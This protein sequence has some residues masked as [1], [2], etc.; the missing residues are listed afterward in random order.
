MTG[1]GPKI[2]L[3]RDTWSSRL[4]VGSGTNDSTRKKNSVT[5]TTM[6]A[7]TTLDH[8]LAVAWASLLAM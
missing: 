3:S 5:E 6:N 2:I 1:H 8:V 4:G 7:T